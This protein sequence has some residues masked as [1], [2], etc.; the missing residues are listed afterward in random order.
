MY[1]GWKLVLFFSDC[2][3]QDIMCSAK[4]LLIRTGVPPSFWQLKNWFPK[5]GCQKHISSSAQTEGQICAKLQ[6][7]SWGITLLK[8]QEL[9]E[10]TEERVSFEILSTHSVCLAK[11]SIFGASFHYH[12]KMIFLAKM[13]WQK[14]LI[15]LRAI[16][17]LSWRETCM[18]ASSRQGKT[19]KIWRVVPKLIMAGNSLSIL[20]LNDSG[21]CL[22]PT[23]SNMEGVARLFYGSAGILWMHASLKW[24][25][26]FVSKEFCIAIDALH[27]W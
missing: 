4:R 2:Q 18:T 10:Q 19:I 12:S 17:K 15:D 26:T 25:P 24:T 3:C 20:H 7:S 1:V 13:S 11:F 8:I 27:C 9:L 23:N 21:L 14:A 6:Q 5:D 22:L 16:G